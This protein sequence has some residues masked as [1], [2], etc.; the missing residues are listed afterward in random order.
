MSKLSQEVKDLAVSEY[1]KGL[2]VYKVAAI[3]PISKT[4]LRN[5]LTNRGIKHRSQSETI[6]KHKISE[7]SIYLDRNYRLY[8]I[9]EPDKGVC[10]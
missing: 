3:L 4:S 8:K 10:Y 5:E 6:R 2:S 9:F 7:S 1:V